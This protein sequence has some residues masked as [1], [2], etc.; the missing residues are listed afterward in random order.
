MRVGAADQQGH[1]A[2]GNVSNTV[3]IGEL[4]RWC[5]LDGFGATAAG[6]PVEAV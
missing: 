6:S 1:P 2:Q 5:S 4:A 3:Q